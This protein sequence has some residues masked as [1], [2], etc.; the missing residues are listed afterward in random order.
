[1]TAASDDLD[2]SIRD[3]SA[4]EFIA[5]ATGPDGG[6]VDLMAYRLDDDDTPTYE[7]E[8][9]D[10]EERL[11]LVYLD[12]ATGGA[13][14][15]S[16]AGGFEVP[17]ADLVAAARLLYRRLTV[18]AHGPALSEPCAVCARPGDA[19]PE[20]DV[21]AALRTLAEDAAKSA[22]HDIPLD[23]G[24]IAAQVQPILGRAIAERAALRQAV[25]ELRD[26]AAGGPIM[27]PA[28]LLDV[29][30]RRLDQLAAAS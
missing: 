22:R 21:V 29:I 2:P 17:A 19:P 12:A 28:P 14:A 13:V 7:V 9:A 25:A 4:D 20:L 8:T 30:A 11:G 23:A 18:C 24:A 26:L 1:M 3:G 10:D 16:E 6:D 27:E 15:L 5:S